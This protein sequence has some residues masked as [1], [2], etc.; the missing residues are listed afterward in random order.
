MAIPISIPDLI[1]GNTVESARIEYKRSWNPESI[2]HT[3]CAF[4]ND[5]DNWGGGYVVIGIE[6]INGMPASVVGVCRSQIDKISKELQNLCNRI[7]PRYLPIY[8]IVE[9]KGKD[10]MVLW[11]PGGRT[12][13]YKCPISLSKEKSE[14]AYYIRKISSTVKASVSE[15]RELFS[16]AEAIPFDDMPN[17]YANMG[18]LSVA[19]MTEFLQAVGSSLYEKTSKMTIGE[20]AEAMHLV[21]GPIEDRKPLNVALMFFND[22]PDRFFPYARI[23]IVDK[24]DPT[25]MSMTEKI[26]SGPLDRQLKDA[27]SYIKNYVIAE[28]IIKQ[29]D[30]PES[31]RV[32]NYPLAAVEEALSNAV[33]HKNYQIGEPITVMITK[34]RMEITSIPGPD[35]SISDMDV[36][37]LHMVS[38][39]YRNRR[40][41]DFLKELRLAEGRNTGVPR[42]VESMGMNNSGFP[43]FETDSGRSYTTVILPINRSFLQDSV[44][45][46]FKTETPKRRT[47]EE[48]INSVLQILSVN[49]EMSIREISDTMGYNSVPSSLRSVVA[50]LISDGTIEYICE[51]RR[52]SKQKVRLKV[53]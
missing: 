5:F 43:V 37:N 26:F 9:Y 1:G 23:E 30:S 14:K 24:P 42:M 18:D 20:I 8:E 13:P 35:R 45:D 22:R 3:I 21:E 53:R 33:Y 44:Q 41:G 36:K 16:M 40:I 25:G 48:I 31:I 10:V 29:D 17:M 11:V 6:E 32:F 49:D 52:S 4:A 39:R 38:R 15:E 28:K 2:M 27:L 50:M 47:R 34:D 46:S 19:L 12:R 51:D 7:E